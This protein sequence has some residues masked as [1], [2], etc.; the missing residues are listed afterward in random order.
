MSNYGSESDDQLGR[1]RVK[2][3]FFDYSYWSYDESSPN[4]TSQSVVFK[5]LG[6]GVVQAADEG[7]NACIFAYGQTGS[8]KTHT[9][10]GQTSNEG[11]IPRI[12]EA[13]FQ[14][15]RAKEGEGVSFRSE[16][17]YLEI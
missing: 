3:F 16:V 4:F 12:C 5:D 17:S 15:I 6:T 14:Q 11:L 1:E 13:L 7:Y 2:D 8:G 9:M 10:M